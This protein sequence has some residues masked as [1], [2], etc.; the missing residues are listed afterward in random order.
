MGGGAT[1]FSS[2]ISVICQGTV[3]SLGKSYN[4]NEMQ[5][6]LPFRPLMNSFVA[7]SQ[8]LNIVPR[9]P[10]RLHQVFGPLEGIPILDSQF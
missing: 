3:V 7:S 5:K 9:G 2:S 6:P 1:G 8:Q 4:T 10:N